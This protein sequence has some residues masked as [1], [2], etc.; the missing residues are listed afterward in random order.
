MREED[1]IL[2]SCPSFSHPGC[3]SSSNLSV[4][5]SFPVINYT[6]ISSHENVS[7]IIKSNASSPASSNS[8]SMAPQ[9]C[10][11][12]ELASSVSPPNIPSQ[13]ESSFLT[14]CENSSSRSQI[15]CSSISPDHRSSVLDHNYSTMTYSS[16]SQIE[17]NPWLPLNGFSSM[18]CSSMSQPALFPST[19]PQNCSCL[20]HCSSTSMSQVTYSSL[21]PQSCKS[22]SEHPQCPNTP[23]INGASTSRTNNHSI[24][25]LYSSSHYDIL[26]TEDPID[27]LPI[28]ISDNSIV[29]E[30]GWSSTSTLNFQPANQ[31]AKSIQEQH[32]KSLS[33]DCSSDPSISTAHITCICT[34]ELATD[35]HPEISSSYLHSYLPNSPVNND[36]L[37]SSSVD[38]STVNSSGA[39]FPSPQ[40]SPHPLQSQNYLDQSNIITLNN[41]VTSPQVN[42]ET[43][44]YG[45]FTSTDHDDMN[46][47]LLNPWSIQSFQSP[48]VPQI[49][50]VSNND[51]LT[52][53]HLTINGYYSAHLPPD[54]TCGCSLPN[55]VDS[56][57]NSKV[58]N[59]SSSNTPPA[60][61]SMCPN[62]TDYD[63][64]TNSHEKHPKMLHMCLHA[65]SSGTTPKYLP[66]SEDEN[67]AQECDI[68]NASLENKVRMD[69]DRLLCEHF[70]DSLS[71]FEDWLQTAQVA[72][73]PENP[74]KTLHQEAK[75][76]LRKYE[77]ILTEIREKLLDLESLN[78]QYWRLTQT[79]QQTLLPSV[80]R[81]RMQEVNALWHSLQGEAETLHRTLKTRVQQ[82]ED[83][84]T[85]QDEMKLCLT[86]M[87][88]ELSNVEYIYG[89]NS[90]EKI[91]QLK[92]FQEDV[93]SNM[94]RVEGLL[95]R[96]D[97]LIDN[98]D[99][100]DA[101]DLEVEM[102]E[103]GSYCQQI[104]IRLSRLQK[105]LVSTRLVFEDD[106]LDGAIEHLSSGSSDVFLDLDIED[107]DVLGPV[108]VPV[109][110]S[111]LPVDL[112]WDP[113]GDVGRSSS[114]DGQESF[115]TATS[116]PWKL[117]QK[118]EGSRSSL[119]SYSGITNSNMR[120]QETK[121][122]LEDISND[123]PSLRDT[124]HFEWSQE[125][126]HGQVQM[127]YTS[128][129]HSSLLPLETGTGQDMI[130][131]SVSFPGD[132]PDSGS[133]MDDHF[134]FLGFSRKPPDPL[135]PL[136]SHTE[137]IDGQLQTNCSGQR[138]RQRKKKRVTRN[139]DT[140]GTLKPT[141]PDV[142]IL[143][144][145]GD[146]LY[147][148]G[149]HKT[150]YRPS[151]SLC[152][153]IKRLAFASVL[154]LILV[155]SLLFPWGHQ[156]CPSKRFTW[157]LMLSYVNGPPP[158]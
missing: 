13:T 116:A 131:C 96:G 9:D 6:S 27:F 20:T 134:T 16:E 86:E 121:E 77:V 53:D 59:F 14:P 55:S 154:L 91:Q 148:L 78:R 155:T 124:C 137:V 18:N 136:T 84:E 32:S 120:R 33:D 72:T 95:E 132:Q 60:Q 12:S 142:S 107:G 112:E 92:A 17:Y 64:A 126:I 39:P 104:Y 56:L 94:K 103:L 8:S 115:Y 138:R 67:Q 100:L 34:C 98:S 41:G 117:P 19:S 47:D 61:D 38:L 26:P 102:T 141:K 88:L 143:M 151:C 79:P 81:S 110:S 24:S 28:S 36:Y 74:Y 40:Q 97:Q 63:V 37:L 31:H 145:N 35:V 52:V 46:F 150:S 89:G 158:T 122:T 93:W 23:Q 2:K 71:R 129:R 7:L 128:A 42:A 69:Q 58:L 152:F 48:T 65:F 68:C 75:L 4:L 114:H 139:L 85:D 108:N 21:L 109:T 50:V 44:S 80:L 153:W 99:P 118:S 140:K 111:A 130:P 82:R 25:P 149:L 127:E 147:R 10:S 73:S 119:S 123:H 101:A 49:D 29:S 66:F 125:Q 43:H 11:S 144:E 156:T 113:L 30:Y 62:S 5:T 3:P 57:A 70:L 45:Q 54:S 106:F 157:S 83:F 133:T 76:A 105:R 90:T 135:S 1:I 51:D 22:L 87:D 15:A 146:E